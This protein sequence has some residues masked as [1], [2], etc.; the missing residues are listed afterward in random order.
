LSLDDPEQR[1]LLEQTVNDE[2]NLVTTHN[3]GTSLYARTLANGKQI[4][5]H[6]KDGVI[7]KGGRN[8]TPY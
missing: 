5:A 8:D 4:W 3:D 7:V 1:Q 6:A 2:A